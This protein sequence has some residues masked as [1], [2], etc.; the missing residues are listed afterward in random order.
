MALSVMEE[1]RRATASRLADPLALERVRGLTF[2]NL[3]APM[4][5]QMRR[6]QVW[7][8]LVDIAHRIEIDR[9]RGVRPTGDWGPRVPAGGLSIVITPSMKVNVALQFGNDRGGRGPDDLRGARVSVAGEHLPESVR[10]ACRGR[11][12]GEIVDVARY[13]GLLGDTVVT[14]VEPIQ[15]GMHV[16]LAL[17]FVQPSLDDL[18]RMR[19][20]HDPT[21]Y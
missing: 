16:H 14:R 10:I 11:H 17:T 4:L 12:L 13:N 6:G 19:D 5:D 15:W 20:I 3:T 8:S 18:E 2:G 9:A 1:V 21:T 7:R